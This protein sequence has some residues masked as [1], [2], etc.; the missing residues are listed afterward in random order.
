MGGPRSRGGSPRFLSNLQ[1]PVPH[2]L[3][4]TG[5][6]SKEFRGPPRFNAGPPRGPCTIACHPHAPPGR[7]K[8]QRLRVHVQV[9]NDTTAGVRAHRRLG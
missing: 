7:A 5:R 3:I 1:K 9:S 6:T 4:E 8:E 2:F